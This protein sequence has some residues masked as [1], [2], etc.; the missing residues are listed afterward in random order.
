VLTSTYRVEI[1]NKDQFDQWDRFVDQSCQGSVYSKSI[2]LQALSEAGRT[3]FEI[4]SVWKGQEIM[5]GVGLH[6]RESRFG[7][8]VHPRGLLY[9]NGL[10]LKKFDSRYPSKLTYKHI[11]IV[12]A[13]LDTLRETPFAAVELSNRAALTDARAFI[14][15]GWSTWVQYTYE[16]PIFNLDQLWEKTEQNIRRLITRC[17]QSGMRMHSS[18][19]FE[20]FFELHKASYARKHL[21]PYLPLDRFKKLYEIL[22]SHD[23]AQLFFILSPEGK[24]LAAQIVLF[25]DHPVTHTWAAGADPEALSTGASALLRW[26]VFQELSRRG[27]THNDLTD[28]MNIS[29]AKFKSQFG[30]DLVPCFVASRVNSKAMKTYERVDRKILQPISAL[31]RK[32][33]PRNR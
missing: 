20:L 29:V 32:F 18:D 15:S 1:L 30:G 23:Y 27:Y 8:I 12:E 10:V 13:L 17:K 7:R 31:A 9:Y 6:Y 4:L 33:V 26:E 25:S 28:A 3:D 19:E 14:W 21:G 5:G 2:F 16:V 24:P 22:C 11:G